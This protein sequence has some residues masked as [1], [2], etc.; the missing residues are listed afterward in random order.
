MGLLRYVGFEVCCVVGEYWAG[1]SLFLLCCFPTPQSASRPSIL[2]K[3][4][5][6]ATLLE[7][8]GKTRHSEGLREPEDS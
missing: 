5:V 4:K 3:D 1:L 7:M 2:D 8:A 6:A